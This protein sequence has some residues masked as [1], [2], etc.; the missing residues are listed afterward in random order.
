MELVLIIGAGALVAGF[1][2]GLAGFGTGLVALGFWL[3]AV[4]PLL[5]APLVVICSVVGQLQA[6]AT[7]RRGIQLARLWPFL[8]GGLLGVPL[9]V[10]VLGAVGSSAEVASFRA[11]VGVFLIVYAGVMLALR[12]LPVIAWGGR[13]ADSAVGL[14][15]GIMGGIAGLS[16]PLPTLWCGLR[17]WSKDA[18]RGVYQPYNLVVRGFALAVYAVQ[19][20]VTARVLELAL[21]CLPMTL[22]GVWLGLRSYG[23]LDDRQFRALVLWLLLA[24]GAI[25]TAS[26]LF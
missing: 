18:Q 20:V 9:G 14:L 12:T 17:G 15:G 13:A 7:L 19:G 24:S 26:N 8:A 1:V 6:T 23:H 10:A 21:I 3:H 22:I 11:G 5:A 16:G 25:L 4:E 2:S